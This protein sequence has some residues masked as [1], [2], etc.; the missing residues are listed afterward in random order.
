M[1]SIVGEVSRVAA[2]DCDV[3]C[4]RKRGPVHTG[5]ELTPAFIEWSIRRLAHGTR[6]SPHKVR[7]HLDATRLYRPPEL[8]ALRAAYA[9]LVEREPSVR[10]YVTGSAIL[11]PARPLKDLD[12]VVMVPDAAAAC[13]LLDCAPR[14]IEWFGNR[15]RVDT[16]WMTG[17]CA[18]Y[19]MVAFDLS[20]ACVWNPEAVH[21]PFVGVVRRPVVT[22]L[23][24]KLFE[25]ASALPPGAGEPVARESLPRQ[26]IPADWDPASERRGCCD[27]PAEEERGPRNLPPRL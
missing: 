14:S 1:T 19:A 7:R 12:V 25:I 17:E 26:Q 18:V 11:T 27:P 13:R 15:V 10:L 2:V 9:P 4:P 16:F 24:E 5:G 22:P 8:E 23:A 20:E 3:A 21:A 6:Y